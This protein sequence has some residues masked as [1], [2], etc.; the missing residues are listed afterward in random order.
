MAVR[1]IYFILLLLLLLLL[2]LHSKNNSVVLNSVGNSSFIFAASS[3]T[4][5]SGVFDYQQ[6]S[7]GEVY[8]RISVQNPYPILAI[9]ITVEMYVTGDVPMV[10]HMC[11]FFFLFRN[12][13]NY[14][15]NIS[16]IL[17]C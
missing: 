1:A 13:I 14:F 4:P 5:C 6:S 11:N 15:L 3:Y 12:I 9:D 2:L 8:G 10:I 7:S 16:A 17:V